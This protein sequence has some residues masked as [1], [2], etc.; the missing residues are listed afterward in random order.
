MHRKGSFAGG[1]SSCRI[2]ALG[3][4]M[5]LALAVPPAYAIES[6]FT[7]EGFLFDADPIGPATGAYDFEFRLEDES[8]SP[9]GATVTLED[10]PVR[11]GVFSVELD[12]GPGAFSE[13]DRY[14]Q[15]AVRR[16]AQTSAFKTLMPRSAIK[17][18]Q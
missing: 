4:L 1:I 10:V 13:E 3:L 7:Y 2:A 15:I 17:P 16:G 9:I 18:G 5:A 8:G 14:L 12:F 6:G 11:A